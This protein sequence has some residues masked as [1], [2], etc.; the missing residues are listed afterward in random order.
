MQANKQP[1]S[2]EQPAGVSLYEQESEWEIALTL[3]EELNSELSLEQ[4]AAK[5]MHHQMDHQSLYEQESEWEIALILKEELDS[6]LSLEQMAAE[7]MMMDHQS[8]YQSLYEK[9]STLNG[10]L[11]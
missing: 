4:M 10:K 9:E 6:E 7:T 1:E 8:L 5:T 11:S 3:K 2:T